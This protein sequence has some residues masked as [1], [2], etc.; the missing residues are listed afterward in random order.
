L[1]LTR[2]ETHQITAK[3]LNFMSKRSVFCF[4]ISVGSWNEKYN[5]H[6]LTIPILLVR[7]SFMKNLLTTKS[8]TFQSAFLNGQASRPYSK[9]GIHLG[10]YAAVAAQLL[11][12]SNSDAAKYGVIIPNFRTLT[13][14]TP[15]HTNKR[16]IAL[17]CISEK[18]VY[19]A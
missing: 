15:M 9:I 18:N 2:K 1:Q 6:S 16:R 8:S 14:G 19:I 4:S 3:H 7:N 13:Q 10:Y 11:L 17:N 12:Y 5:W